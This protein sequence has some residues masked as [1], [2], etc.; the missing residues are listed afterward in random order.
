MALLKKANAAKALQ[1]A[2][3]RENCLKGDEKALF[4][5]YFGFVGGCCK[6]P[7]T[8]AK[9]KELVDAREATLQL[10]EKALAKFNLRESDVQEIEPIRIFSWEEEIEGGV[11]A[12]FGP[13][14]LMSNMPSWTMIY[15]G[16]KQMYV[17][18]AT[19]D[20]L[21]GSI[22]EDA[23]EYFYKDVVSFHT[24]D[25]A[26]TRSK[27]TTIKKCCKTKD[28]QVDLKT[29]ICKLSI[30]V[31]NDAFVTKVCVTDP[32]YITNKVAQA[33][34]KIREKKALVRVER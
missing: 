34:A 28:G 19:V 22:K 14:G 25:T 27:H 5:H 26:A 2:Y 6:K 18:S 15:F 24:V 20:M 33:R 1:R 23:V 30:I 12:F 9:Y 11:D 17:Y 10:K 7:W 13:S 16:D 31:P 4:E 29:F 32:S 3:I 8:D 21:T